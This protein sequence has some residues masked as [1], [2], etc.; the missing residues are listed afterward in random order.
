MGKAEESG[1]SE[2]SAKCSNYLLGEIKA[3]SNIITL[4]T[5]QPGRIWA[6]VIKQKHPGA[7]SLQNKSEGSQKSSKFSTTWRPSGD[8]IHLK[9]TFLIQ[10]NSIQVGGGSYLLWAIENFQ[11]FSDSAEKIADSEKEEKLDDSEKMNAILKDLR[12][13]RDS[14]E[15]IASKLKEIEDEQEIE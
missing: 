6:K 15:N 10:K 11:E 14:C 7:I 5:G 3:S 1:N 13:M 9:V 2:L 4:K 8:Y 12:Y